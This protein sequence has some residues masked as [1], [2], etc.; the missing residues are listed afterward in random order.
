MNFEGEVDTLHLPS[1]TKPHPTKT[2]PPVLQPSFTLI[3]E[4]DGSLSLTPDIHMVHR[5]RSSSL[6]VACLLSQSTFLGDDSDESRTPSPT[7]FPALP[8]L[9]EVV[10]WGARGLTSGTFDTSRP[11]EDVRSGFMKSDVDDIERIMESRG[12]SF[13]EARYL[14][15]Q[16]KMVENGIDPETGTVNDARA[17]TFERLRKT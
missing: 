15:V 13:D 12:I 10:E 7:V 8:T 4:M 3:Q 6:P 5:K 2:S 11:F 16:A 14:H 1:S 9:P 17:V